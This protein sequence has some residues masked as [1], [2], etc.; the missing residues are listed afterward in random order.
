MTNSN[1]QPKT[2]SDR[3]WDAFQIVAIVGGMAI[4]GLIIKAI[5]KA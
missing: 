4:G 2:L 1:E 3:M 5:M